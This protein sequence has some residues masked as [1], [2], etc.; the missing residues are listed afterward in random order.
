M[1]TR[2]EP[3]GGA[4]GAALAE[5]QREAVVARALPFQR[6]EDAQERCR[7]ARAAVGPALDEEFADTLRDQPPVAPFTPRS[8]VVLAVPRPPT[9]ASFVRDDLEH[10][11]VVPPTYARYDEVEAETADR[12]GRL[13]G[14]SGAVAPAPHL[15]LKTLAVG[16]GLARY[17]RNNVAYVP[18]LGSA[19]QLVACVCSLPAGS[20]P[21]QAPQ[22]LPRCERCDACR[23]ACPTGAI[24]DDRFLL[25]TERCLTM[26]N[27]GRLPLP[28]WVHAEWFD[29]PVGCLRCQRACPESRPWPAA[30]TPTRFDADETTALLAASRMDDLS[31]ATRDKL[32]ACGLLMTPSVLARNLR[33][34]L[35]A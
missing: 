4:L 19:V 15:P 5:L 20:D 29:C 12:L 22:P 34:L 2:A 21:W 35:A 32:A 26:V 9:A 7:E 18:G 31:P 10:T 24:A 13:I 14:A 16:S 25:H 30:A 8:V 23:R 1:T 17:G 6:L 33:L 11:F 27:E 3:H 28:E